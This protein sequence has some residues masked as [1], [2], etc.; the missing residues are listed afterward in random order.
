[1]NARQSRRGKRI[2]LQQEKR[3]AADL[4]GR[5]MAASGATRLGGGGDV[6]VIG[7]TRIECKFTE[8]DSY[9]LR[10]E[11]LKKIRTQAMKVLERPVFQFAFRHASGRLRGYAVIPWDV[12]EKPKDSDHSWYTSARSVT[13]TE[14]QLETALQ[15]GKIQFTFM[16]AGTEP[17]QFRLFEI[18]RWHDYVEIE[19]LKHEV[20][21]DVGAQHDKPVSGTPSRAEG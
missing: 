9:T 1:M 21:D 18:M 13:F 8:K 6:R 16:H 3:A 11:E 20:Q 2:S 15:T 14:H 19:T 12:E 4:G 5:T 17:L 10:Y 7:S